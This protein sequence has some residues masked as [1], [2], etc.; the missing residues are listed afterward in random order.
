MAAV[1]EYRQ[2]IPSLWTGSNPANRTLEPVKCVQHTAGVEGGL[3]N[4]AWMT[5]EGFW[6]RY[7][8]YPIDPAVPSR[9]LISA[10]A[11]FET[12]LVGKLMPS[13]QVHADGVD[14]SLS[15]RIG[16]SATV[17]LGYSY[18]DVAQYN[19]EKQ[20][21]PADYDIRHQGRIWFAWHRSRNWTASAMWRYASGRP[22]TPYDVAAS[23]KAKAGRYDR[24]RTNAA[25]YPAYHRLDLRAERVWLLGRT[26]LTAFAEVDNVYNR[27]NISMYEWSRALAQPRPILQWGLTPIAGIRIDF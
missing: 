17:S 24:T 3:W 9:V 1:G 18:W 6:K 5:V 15:Q 21:I 23:V 10:G 7:T 19:L 12:P 13:G 8:G 4:G 2:D 27:D 14:T 26:A 11:D 25:R 20:W 16:R 22:Y